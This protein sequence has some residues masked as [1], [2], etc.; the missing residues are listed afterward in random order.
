MFS[1]RKRTFHLLGLGIC[2]LLIQVVRYCPRAG[3]F[4][5]QKIYPHTARLLSAFSDCLPFSLGDVFILVGCTGILVYACVPFRHIRFKTRLLHIFFFLG[6]IYVWFY[7]AWGLNYFREDFYHRNRVAFVRYSPESFKEFLQE[8]VLRLNSDYVSDVL[9]DTAEIRKDIAKQYAGIASRFGLNLPAGIPREKNMLF[10]PFISKVGV[11]G[12]MGPFFNEFHL[13]AELLPEEY[14]AV[15]AHELAHRLNVA[16]EA[17]ANFYAWLTCTRSSLPAVRYSGHFLIFG[18]VARNAA[19]LLT[20][21]EYEDFI[22]S[23]RPEIIEQYKAHQTYWR[24]KYSPFIGNIQN[25]LYNLF[26]KSNRIS[27]GTKNYSE[28]IGL[29]MS[30]RQAEKLLSPHQ[31]TAKNL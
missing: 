17:E 10:S 13:N 3:E 5:A 6:W 2:L 9:P 16:S 22:R 19:Y 11:S 28:V 4:Y 8:Y 15:Y 25:R 20:Q 23:V 29:I 31:N 7:F 27:S 21:E 12:Y 30:W 14:P 24:K 26:L 1:F 18:Y